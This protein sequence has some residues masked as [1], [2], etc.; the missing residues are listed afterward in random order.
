MH[1]S[2]VARPAVRLASKTSSSLCARQQS[3][4]FHRTAVSMGQI[5]PNV[6]FDTIAREWRAKWSPDADKASL[7]AA[8]AELEKVLP[9]LKGVKGSKGVQRVV[10]GSCMD[11]KVITSVNGDDFGAWE[12]GGFAP[13]KDFLAALEKI[14]GISQIETQTVTI[15]PM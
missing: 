11:F 6:G 12:E 13:E 9:A 8:Q 5:T 14:D 3:R 15:M 7:S 1:L 2:S 4:R 10:C